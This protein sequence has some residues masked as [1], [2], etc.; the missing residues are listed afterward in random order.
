MHGVGNSTL[1]TI[2]NLVYDV[3]VTG[4]NYPIDMV[5]FTQNEAIGCILGMDFRQTHECKLSIQQGY[6]YIN[7]MKIKLRRESATNTV[8]RI[9]LIS[10]ITLPA[11]TELA[12]SGR[13]EHMSKKI[14]SYYSCI[15][16]SP[17][18]HG[19]VKY[20][21]MTGCSVVNTNADNI[22]VPLINTW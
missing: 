14:S 22:V 21:I 9:K 7:G 6:L 20:N 16:P 2:G 17:I 19:M 5:V 13:P 1:P 4:R 18:M 10:N 12:V 3:T 11:P 15:E 8:A